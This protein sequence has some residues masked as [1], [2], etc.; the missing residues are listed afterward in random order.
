MD[1]A[2]VSMSIANNKVQTDVGTAMLAKSLDAMET[3]G[4][5]LVSL[6]ESADAMSGKALQAAATGLGQSV[7]ISI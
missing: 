6:I 3:A 5:G 7:D 1:I 4:G 2:Q